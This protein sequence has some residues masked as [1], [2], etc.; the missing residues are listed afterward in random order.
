MSNP[1]PKMFSTLNRSAS[2]KQ[3][4]IAALAYKF[5]LARAFR[6]G[7]PEQDW[8]QA[9]HAV[10]GKSGAATLRRTTVADYLVL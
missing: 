4:K 2:A 5:W 6:S 8:L 10:L 3:R 1:A 9:E 7:S